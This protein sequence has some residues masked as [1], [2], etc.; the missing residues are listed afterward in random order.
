MASFMENHVQILKFL[1]LGITMMDMKFDLMLDDSR[2]QN[3]FSQLTTR[4]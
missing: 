2:H 1:Y 4:Q 3:L